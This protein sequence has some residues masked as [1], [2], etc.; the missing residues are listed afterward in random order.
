MKNSILST[1][2]GVF[3]FISYIIGLNMGNSHSKSQLRDYQISTDTIGIKVYDK[4]RYV[5]SVSWSN[6][7]ALD[8]LIEDDNQ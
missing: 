8:G 1:L 3:C 4:D 5:G 7:C 2:V 6:S